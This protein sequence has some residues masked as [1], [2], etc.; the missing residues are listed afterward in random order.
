MPMTDGDRLWLLAIDLR[1]VLAE[2]ERHQP[3]PSRGDSDSVAQAGRLG[4][5]IRMADDLIAR[6]SVTPT[7]GATP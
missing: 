7:T 3:C 4:A 1:D 5:A 2:I 6:L